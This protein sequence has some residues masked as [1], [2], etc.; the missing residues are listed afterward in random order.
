MPDPVLIWLIGLALVG[1]IVGPFVVAR[2]RRERAARAAAAKAERAGL[3]QPASLHPVIDPER[4]LGCGACTAVCP[5]G[6][7]LALVGAQAQVIAPARCVGHGRCERACPTDAISL[8]FGTATRGVELPRVR[9]DYMTNVD[10]L[11]IVG[12]LGGMGLVRNAVEQGRQCAEGIVK[13]IRA[14]GPASEMRE[15]AVVGAGPAGL[16]AAATLGAA[17]VPYVVL[18][19]ATD[20]G[21]TVRQYPRRKLVMTQPFEIPGY[22]RLD[23]TEISKESLV[24]LWAE[25]A[26]AAGVEDQTRLGMRVTNIT[27]VDGGFRIE[28]EGGEPV[29]ARRVVLAIGRRGTPRTLGVPGDGQGHVV[30]ALMEPEAYAGRSCLVV[31]GGDSAVEAAVALAE[32]GAEVRLSYRKPAITRAKAANV[33]RLAQAVERGAITPLWASTVEAIGADTA[34]LDTPGG[35]VV[36]PADDVFVLIGGEPPTPFL[37]RCGIVLD[38]HF[39]VPRIGSEG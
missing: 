7:V 24:E 34:R 35:E 19:R 38:T 27:R 14:Q 4:C 3:H 12:E 29:E 10:G 5:E 16:S 1:G 2:R 20:L 31:G 8:V 11:Y 26:D 28:G 22:G 17:D 18:E 37:E 13:A 23:A 6:D 39:G 30:Y 36:V 25:V 21:G 15:V 9:G 33:S 32:E